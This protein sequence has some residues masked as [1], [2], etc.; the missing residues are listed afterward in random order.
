[1]AIAFVD[2]GLGALPTA[3]L[4]RELRP[5]L[6]L[7]LSMDPDHMPWGPRSDDQVADRALACADA[8]INEGAS[9]IVLACNTASV[10]ALNVVR[11]RYEPGVPVVGT[12]PAIKPAAAL[13]EPLAIWATEGTTGSK[14]QEQLIAQFAASLQVTQVS[15]ASLAEAIEVFDRNAIHAI[16]SA[17]VARTPKSCSAVVL[18]CTQYPLVEAV[19]RD[20]LPDGCEVFHSAAPVAQQVLRR[21][22]LEPL[23]PE[24]V[25]DQTPIGALTVLLSGRRGALPN[26]AF[27]YESGATLAR[28]HA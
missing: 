5:D 15:C 26:A 12:V 10:L 16:V 3:A 23:R 6:P 22:S 28:L 17:A 7:I 24:Q 1:V 19:I 4:V 11:D 8:A 14:Y 21:L 20:H 13:G 25:E 27:Q 2:S 18:G 9:A